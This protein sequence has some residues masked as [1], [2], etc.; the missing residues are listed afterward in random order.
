VVPDQ[1]DTRSTARLL[2]PAWASPEQVLGL[3][4]TTASDV[5]QL[6][7]LLYRLLTG[8]LPYR[9]DEKRAALLARAI[10]EEPALVPSRIASGLPDG[11]QE[12]GQALVAATARAA[13][14]RLSP[15]G[16]R[17][18]LAG[19]LDAIVLKALRK[20]PEQRYRSVGQLID[21][22]E[23]HLA[24][25]LV[26][27][28]PATPLYRATSFVR[29]R[30]LLV[31]LA[32]LAAVSLVGGLVATTWQA[33][34]AERRFAEGR[35]LARALLFDLHDAIAALPGSTRAREQLVMTSLEYLDGLAA[36]AGNDVGLLRELAD[37]YERVGDVQG[38]PRASNLGEPSAA[39][40]SYESA[41][42]LRTRLATRDE[43]LAD[44][45][46]RRGIARVRVKRA[47]LLTSQGR[48][49]EALAELR[50]AL[51]AA[52][53]LQRRADRSELDDELLAD[54]WGALGSA[55]A[56]VNDTAAAVESFR[57]GLAAAEAWR[58][59]HPGPGASRAMSLAQ[60]RLGNTLAE[61]GALVDG[62]AHL[63]RAAELAEQAARVRPDDPE[64]LRDVRVLNAWLGNVLGVPAYVSL[65][66]LGGAR[67]RY[68]RALEAGEALVTR[69]P[70]DAQA[71]LGLSVIYWRLGSLEIERD[72]QAA[73]RHIERAL[74]ILDELLQ[75]SPGSF[76]LQRRRA[77]VR[78][79]LAVALERAG[80][81]EPA[82][83]LLEELLEENAR[84]D[85][86][87]GD[88][89]SVSTARRAIL[90]QL[91]TARLHRG[92]SRAALECH[93]A[94]LALAE[95]WL[96]QRPD[97]VYALAALAESHAGIAAAQA[98]LAADASLGIDSRREHAQEAEQHQRQRLALLEQWMMRVP[99]APYGAQQHAAAQADL[100]ALQ[101]LA[102]RLEAQSSSGN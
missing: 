81:R 12:P 67:A 91:G 9:A 34:R 26:G 22:V 27:A 57:A 71:R 76:D 5:Y 4:V 43:A 95:S 49:D 74:A 89:I 11:K 28:R 56:R 84:L 101:S 39:T 31:S 29:R 100:R 17:R 87:R 15:R 61:R 92:Q 24:G 96:R 72:P 90:Q 10:V 97:D 65:G 3:P 70:G 36:E 79:S 54:A 6:G 60:A 94:E 45:E 53:A 21:D 50:T 80:E 83:M 8:R 46:L 75:L 88:D 40:A 20:E 85:E 18:A 47:D 30:W 98:G 2:T 42:A 58:E 73:R 44:A 66:D 52:Q 48:F 41:L 82:L 99:E 25:R 78:L 55:Q 86:R 37:A 7:L 62:I 63:E 23:R 13:Q 35:R 32:S 38:G 16:L 64:A 19:D 68:E 51:D 69:D 93:E 77:A 14:L 33:R 102:H 1:G 59:A